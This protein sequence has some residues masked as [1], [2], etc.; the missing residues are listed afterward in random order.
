MQMMLADILQEAAAT[1]GRTGEADLPAQ[2]DEVHVQVVP[3]TF[4][5]YLLEKVLH[6]LPRA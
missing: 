6:L 1:P 3:I 4:R 2:A 5:D